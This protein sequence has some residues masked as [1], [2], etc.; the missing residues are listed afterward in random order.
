[1]DKIKFR[2]VNGNI[3]IA[4]EYMEEGGWRHYLHNKMINDDGMFNDM[5]WGHDKACLR[6]QFTGVYDIGGNEIYVDDICSN[7]VAKWI[8]VF[9]RGCFSV[10]MVGRESSIYLALRGVVGLRVIGNIHENK[11]LING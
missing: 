4:T 2:V 7:D 9:D 11:N 3:V 8:V 1:M 10:K 5:F 6:N